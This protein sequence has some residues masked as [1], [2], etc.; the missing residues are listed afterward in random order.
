MTHEMQ[1]ALLTIALAAA[2]ADGNGTDAE[3]GEIRRVAGVASAAADLNLPALY[4]DVLLE[5]RERQTAAR[6]LGD[7][8]DPGTRVPTRRRSLRRRR[9]AVGA[10]RAFLA[11]LCAALAMSSAT[12][13]A[14]NTILKL[15]YDYF[16]FHK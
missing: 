7:A 1:K 9:G 15:G 10:E 2:F 8:A 12:A 5:A 16:I 6:A 4:Q 3:R 14:I 13:Q 11:S